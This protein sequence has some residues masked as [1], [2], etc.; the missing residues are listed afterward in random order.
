MAGQGKSIGRK[1]AVVTFKTMREVRFPKGMKPNENQLEIIPYQD[2]LKH[3][4][5]LL[6]YEWLVKYFRV[7]EG[8]KLALTNPREQIIAKGGFIFFARKEN[9]ILGTAALLR[10]TD[11]VYELGKMAVSSHVR[12]VGVGTQLLLHCIRFARQQGIEKLILYSNTRLKSAIHLYQKNG[13]RKIALE[14]GLYERANIK[15]ELDLV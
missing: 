2:E 3:Y 1:A 12:G 15:M 13:F 9:E 11:V 8:D 4:I 5:K 14:K 6:N 10:K 7:E